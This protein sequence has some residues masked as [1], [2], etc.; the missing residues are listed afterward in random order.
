[1]PNSS[2]VSSTGD[3]KNSDVLPLNASVCGVLTDRCDASPEL[4]P[5]YSVT[6]PSGVA[7]AEWNARPSREFSGNS[8]GSRQTEPPSLSQMAD[9][10]TTYAWNFWPLVHFGWSDGHSQLV[11]GMSHATY[12]PNRQVLSGQSISWR[13][14]SSEVQV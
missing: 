11:D 1:M 14:S 4:K 7:T 8:D 9:G 13:Q 6:L 10:W 12:L 5:P 3:W 2:L